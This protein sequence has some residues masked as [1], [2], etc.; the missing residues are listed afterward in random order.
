MARGTLKTQPKPREA[1]YTAVN[2]MKLRMT[3]AG[4]ADKYDEAVRE[5]IYRTYQDDQL[6]ML[7]RAIRTS[8]MYQSGGKSK[9]HRKILEFPNAYVYDFCDTVLTALYGPDW[10]N[11]HRALKHELVRPWHVV[12]KL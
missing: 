2:D 3:I 6:A 5:I 12:E 10:L 4:L 11:N 8:G 1:Q 7:Y 9:V